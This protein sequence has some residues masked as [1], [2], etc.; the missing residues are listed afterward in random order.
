M[1]TDAENLVAIRSNIL[2]RLADITAQPKPSYDIDGQ[3]VKWN[4]YQKMLFDQLTAT[5][6]A[7]ASGGP[8]VVE[9]Q[10]IT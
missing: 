3:D 5:D 1:A 7:I 6:S 10:A 9:T 2:Q 8:F 4:E